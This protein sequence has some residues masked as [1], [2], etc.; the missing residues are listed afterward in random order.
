M[1]MRSVR[2]YLPLAVLI[3]L[4][5]AACG[6]SETTASPAAA[7]SPDVSAVVDGREIRRDEVEKAYRR[8]IDPGAAP[9][10][11]DATA[12][13]LN[14]LDQLI[15][16]NLLLAR[17][18]ALNIDVP[19]AELDTA[20]AE[21]QKGVPQDALGQELAARNLTNDDMKE[22]LRRDMLV[23]K[24]MEHEVTSKV[25]VSDAD[26]DA[27]YQANKAQFNLP[28]EAF[29]I[30]QIVVTN[31]K[32]P[33]VNN[34][35]G[36][37]AG[38]A[39]AATAK[40]QMLMERL[41]AGASFG[42][43]A[44]D[45]SEDPGSAS[46]GGDVGLVSTTALGQAPPKLRDAVLKSQP[47]SVTVVSMEGGHTIVGLVARLQAGQRDPS[48]SDVRDSITATLRDRREQLLRAAYLETVR[49]GARVVNYDAQRVVESMANAPAAPPSPTAAAPAAPAPG[50]A[51]P[52]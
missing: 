46:K 42:D 23:D 2:A 15:T 14:L 16:Q 50:A 48:M 10:D 7:P 35:T 17:A 38:T 39:E 44:M 52:K 12:A 25:Q 5:A 26:I 34:R 45:Y 1:L 9:A 47:G 8:N 11:E 27:Y 4:L 20:F 51:A 6:G 19:V 36:D 32:D 29:H 37:D 22:A 21:Q 33:A 18:A 3:P 28:E 41:K 24:L 30:I 43:L 13:R 31:E 40:V 49:N